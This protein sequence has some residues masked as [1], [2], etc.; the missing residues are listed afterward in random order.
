MLLLEKK[1]F[2]NE[3]LVVITYYSDLYDSIL[4]DSQPR[5]LN[6]T[7]ICITLPQYIGT[8]YYVPFI[9]GT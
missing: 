2:L 5:L 1:S 3:N 8:I 4:Y 7:T 6:L 9:Y